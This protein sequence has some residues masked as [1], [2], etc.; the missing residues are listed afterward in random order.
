MGL[1]DSS[2]G[3]GAVTSDDDA[4][5]AGW[6][7]DAERVDLAVYAAI[8]ATPTPS[9]D[10][11]MT[12]LA[13]AADRSRLWIA[14]AGARAAGRGAPGRRAAGM[15]LASV[16]VTSAVVNLAMKPLARR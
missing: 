4:A 1:L 14:P 2:S 3:A 16:G 10:R 7:V 5:A 8:A 12:V 11:A 15:G 9:L 13:R 6:L